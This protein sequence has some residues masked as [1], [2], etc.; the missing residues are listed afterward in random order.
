MASGLP[1]VDDLAADLCAWHE[2]G[3]SR[4]DKQ[5]LEAERLIAG[6]DN[7]A[8]EHSGREIDLVHLSNPSARD[9]GHWLR[10]LSGPG[11]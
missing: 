11:A 3:F 5:L 10:G 1:A 4:V 2:G 7:A 9:S 8:A 6:G